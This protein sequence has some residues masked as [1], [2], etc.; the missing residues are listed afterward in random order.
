MV[1]NDRRC[2]TAHDTDLFLRGLGF[3]IQTKTSSGFLC[4]V[5]VKEIDEGKIALG[6]FE[7][8]WNGNK[9]ERVVD[10]SHRERDT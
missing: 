3:C 8:H 1:D 7:V 10:P 5:G 6:K 9:V 4:P 2:C